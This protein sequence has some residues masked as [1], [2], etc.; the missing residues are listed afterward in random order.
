MW[1]RALACRIKF[2]I[3]MET[4]CPVT[5]RSVAK[6][7]SCGGMNLS[8]LPV[9]NPLEHILACV[10]VG[11]FGIAAEVSYAHRRKTLSLRQTRWCL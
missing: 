11:D 7:V 5:R 6:L 10:H 1:R 2:R 9:L 3:H 8:L 4:A